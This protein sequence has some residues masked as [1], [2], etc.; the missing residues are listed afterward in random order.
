M[1]EYKR[2]TLQELWIN[3]FI[4]NQINYSD[5]FDSVYFK[6]D[7]LPSGTQSVDLSQ[8]LT[9]ASASDIYLSSAS[10]SNIYLS[11]ASASD[12]YLTIA[13]ASSYIAGT[14]SYTLNSPS[15]LTVG[16]I[17]AGT[18]L[19]NRT[20]EDILQQLLIVYLSPSITALTS[21]LFTTYEVGQ[22]LPTGT[23]SISYTVSN[24]VN[25]KTQPPN[26]GI[27]S[28]DIPT[29]TF[30]VNPI[31]LVSS[32]S[33][34]ISIPSGITSNVPASMTVSLQGTNSNNI[35]FSRT[36]T[37]FFRQRVFWGQSSS[38]SLTQ[39]DILALSNSQLRSGFNA[40]YSFPTNGYKYFCYPASMGTATTFTDTSNGF[41]VA[42][43]SVVSTVSVTNAYGVTE[44]YNVHRTLN[45]LGGSINI[46]I[47]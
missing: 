7:I 42:M 13:S 40:T 45:V 20:L 24:S 47:S 35:T 33:F 25:I 46:A 23:T 26:V 11:S 3:G 2:K 43:Y 17:P 5:L 22:P 38:T 27:I 12:I 30:P 21:G 28:T 41:P 1:A 15:N 34:S 29:A 39:S 10:A 8:Y 18:V 32:S 14:P 44:N 31:L 36:S 16:G 9:I 4:P 6:D 37:L 19:T